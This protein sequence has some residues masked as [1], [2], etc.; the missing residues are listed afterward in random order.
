MT[1]TCWTW[2]MAPVFLSYSTHARSR[3]ARCRP[4]D[5]I[6][7]KDS[8]RQIEHGQAELAA[9][10]AAANI[11]LAVDAGHVVVPDLGRKAEAGRSEERRVGKECRSRWSPY[12]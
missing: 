2:W 10:S 6:C 7:M 3:T 11:H 5:T 4:R 1:T 8:L 12:H 9:L